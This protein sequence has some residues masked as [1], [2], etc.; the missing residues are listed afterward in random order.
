MYLLIFPAL[1]FTASF[2]SD[3]VSSA[4]DMGYSPFMLNSTVSEDL[5]NKFTKST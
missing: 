2:D 5:S 1:G 3:G 4:G